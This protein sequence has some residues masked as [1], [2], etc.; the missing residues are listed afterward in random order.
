MTEACQSC[1]RAEGHHKTELVKTSGFLIKHVMFKGSNTFKDTISSAFQLTSLIFVLNFATMH[2]ICS[3]T[4][5]KTGNFFFFKIPN[6]NNTE[7]K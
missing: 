1:A 7:K 4:S 5:Q 3:R 2:S 6:S